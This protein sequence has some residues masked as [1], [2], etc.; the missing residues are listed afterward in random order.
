MKRL[1]E[2]TVEELAAVKTAEQQEELVAFEAMHRGVPRPILQEVPKVVEVLAPHL[3]GYRVHG[4]DAMFEASADAEALATLLVQQGARK[5]E[6]DWGT[7]ASRPGDRYTPS[8]HDLMVEQVL[9]Y[10]EDEWIAH[11]GNL[12]D[13]ERV[14]K[15]I[16]RIRKENKA[17]MGAYR[18]VETDVREAISTAAQREWRR[19]QLAAR[20]QE[21]VQMAGGNEEIAATFFE[22]AYAADSEEDRDAVL[23][24]HSPRLQQKDVQ[25]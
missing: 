12:K 7:S 17:A 18:D 6:H 4:I 3:I 14:E 24:P 2:M 23:G 25:G 16:E 5:I 20:F 22:K 15:E 9:G 10:T 19:G 21:Y 8:G 1:E 11:K 13:R